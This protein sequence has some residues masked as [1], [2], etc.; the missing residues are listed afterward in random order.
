MP[1]TDAPKREE[2]ARMET[3][4]GSHGV[5]VLVALTGELDAADTAWIEEL[6]GLIDRGGRE[7]VIDLLGVSF[8]DSSVVQALILAHQRVR[9]GG[10]VRVVYTHHLIKRVL[11]IC[12]LTEVF[13]QYTTVEAALRAVPTRGLA[14]AAAAH[15]GERL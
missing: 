7:I 5:P 11:E 3:S 10:W 1:Q 6:D 2:E 4:T 15:L 9:D 8:I 13:P 12:G 14:A